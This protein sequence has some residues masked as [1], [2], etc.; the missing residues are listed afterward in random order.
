MLNETLLCR[1]A[2]EAMVQP[3][4]LST[5]S[6]NACTC[7]APAWRHFCTLSCC[8]EGLGFRLLRLT[9]ETAPPSRRGQVA[10]SG[11]GY[12]LS[13]KPL[14]PASSAAR[15]YGLKPELLASA[16]REPGT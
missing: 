9:D 6:V 3:D 15:A 13:G 12:T 1:F 8:R 4:L 2:C 10:E 5:E 7:W 14:D 16:P 11:E